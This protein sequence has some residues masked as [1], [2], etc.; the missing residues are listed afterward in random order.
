MYITFYSTRQLATADFAPGCA[1]YWHT[2]RVMVNR[3]ITDSKLIWPIIW[4][5]DV[6]HKI[7]QELIRRWDSESELLRSAPGCYPNLLK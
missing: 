6:I 1:I 2:W 4:K 3:N 7:T 5:H